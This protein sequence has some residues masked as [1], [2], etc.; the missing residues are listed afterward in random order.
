MQLHLLLKEVRNSHL[1]LLYICQNDH[2]PFGKCEPYYVCSKKEM[3]NRSRKTILFILFF[4]IKKKKRKNIQC[5]SIQITFDSCLNGQYFFFVTDN[6]LKFTNHSSQSILST[7]YPPE[8]EKY[9]VI[10]L[11]LLKYNFYYI[12]LHN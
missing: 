1:Y 11:Y 5:T 2:Y 6:F 3:Q 10:Y 4:P 12:Y 9:G 8:W 7:I